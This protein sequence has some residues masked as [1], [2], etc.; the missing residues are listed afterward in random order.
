MA[1]V[2]WTL[3]RLDDELAVFQEAAVARLLRTRISELRVQIGVGEARRPSGD[4]R[5]LAL[6]VSACA[7]L[8]YSGRDGEL[9]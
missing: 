3:S 6:P 7:R 5:R 1:A 2:R 8:R 4:F 9:S